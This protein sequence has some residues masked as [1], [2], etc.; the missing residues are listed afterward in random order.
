[1]DE[2]Y[3]SYLITEELTTPSCGWMAINRDMPSE[4]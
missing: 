4:Y 3:L 2:A 1:M